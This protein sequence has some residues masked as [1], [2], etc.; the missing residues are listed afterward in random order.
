MLATHL[1]ARLKAAALASLQPSDAR[2]CNPSQ[3]MEHP[4]GR[5]GRP[6]R[7]VEG[8]FDTRQPELHNSILEATGNLLQ[9]N[10]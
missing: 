3:N 8:R 5:Q 7:T 4:W 2:Y 6:R 9:R 10:G 1:P